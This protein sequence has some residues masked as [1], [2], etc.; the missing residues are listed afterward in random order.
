MNNEYTLYE[1]PLIIDLQWFAA[2]DEGRTEDPTET[3]L[4]KA[5]EE[6]RVPKSQDMNSALVVFF[7][8]LALILLAPHILNSCMEILKFFFLRCIQADIRS[9]EWFF[10]FIKYFA[11]IVFPITFIALTAGVLSNLIQN[12]GFLFS[13]KPIQPKFDK[14]SPNI[15][16]F[17]TRA[18]FSIEGLFNLAKSLMKVAAIVFVSYLI[19]KSNITVFISMLQVSFVQAVFYIAGLA[20][21]ILAAVSLLLLL[22][23]IPDYFFQRKQFIDSLKMSKSEI[24]EEIKE[25]EGDP[26]IKS[27]LRRQMQA[28]VRESARG[29]ATADVVITNPTHYAV[30]VKYDLGE[31]PAPIVI[32]KGSDQLAQRIK[33]I[34]RENNIPIEENKPLARS[35]YAQVAIGKEVPY[36]YFNALVLIFTKLDKFKMQAQQR[37]DVNG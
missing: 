27:Q 14:I 20:A 9:G 26:L 5:R 18:L 4:R 7:P 32:A 30:A 31:M 1:L 37:G 10:V 8:A 36:E 6:G 11:Q 33:E 28:I 15:V 19:I 24:K 25:Q 29:A 23:A 34:A 2:E 21:K 22:F 17:F 35:L 13:T 16:R 12:R 3:K